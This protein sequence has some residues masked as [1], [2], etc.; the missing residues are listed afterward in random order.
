M[1]VGVGTVMFTG[2]YML[3]RSNERRRNLKAEKRLA[4]IALVPLLQVRRDCSDT[5]WYFSGCT[6]EHATFRLWVVSTESAYPAS[7]TG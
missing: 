7:M 2:L 3:G 4:R 6:L 5:V 1:F